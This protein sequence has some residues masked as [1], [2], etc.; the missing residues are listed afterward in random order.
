MVG[1]PTS[2]PSTDRD[3]ALVVIGDPMTGHRCVPGRPP[4]VQPG[5]Q[6]ISVLGRQ[7]PRVVDDPPAASPTSR[8]APGVVDCIGC[9]WCTD[10]CPTR[11]RPIR[12][13]QMHESMVDDENLARQLPWCIDCGLCSH[14]CPAFI[15]LAQLLR[16]AR[17]QIT[18]ASDE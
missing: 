3:A 17:E 10:V 9:G 15:P 18:G 6:L 5:D 12:L 1:P 14:V 13:L 4:T 16:S 11:L 7:V 8:P 2:G